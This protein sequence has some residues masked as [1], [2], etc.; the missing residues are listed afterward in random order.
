LLDPALAYLARRIW[1]RLEPYHA[2]T[3]FAPESRAAWESV[4][5]KG[6]WM[7]YFASRAAAMGAVGPKVVTA[8]F[9][10][11][12]PSRVERAVPDCWHITT[13]NAILRA[14]LDGVVDA[15]SAAADIDLEAVKLLAPLARTVAEAVSNDIGGR[16][17]FAAHAQQPWPEQGAALQAWWAATLIREHRGDG[18]IAALLDAGIGPCEALVL[19]STYTAIPREVLQGSRKWPDD[20]WELAIAS[21]I[22]RGWLAADGS[23]NDT[24]RDGLAAIEQRTDELAARPLEMIGVD[25]AAALAEAALPVAESV[26]KSGVVPSINPIFGDELI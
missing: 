26:M 7:G 3:Y 15:L 23:G 19:Q 16:P 25:A 4:G 12:H 17:L 13:P 22:D 18:H 21:L 2:I 8:T 10:N 24:G 5:M 6:F 1:R 11:F 20:Q 14:R 9:Y